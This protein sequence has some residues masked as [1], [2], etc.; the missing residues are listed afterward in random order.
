[1]FSLYSM[2]HEIDRMLYMARPWLLNLD[3]KHYLCVRRKK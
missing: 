1:M 2:N 3:V